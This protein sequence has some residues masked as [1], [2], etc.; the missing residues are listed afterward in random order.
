[1]EPKIN[2]FSRLS[3]TALLS[4][5]KTDSTSIMG[6]EYLD[7]DSKEFSKYK[8]SIAEEAGYS[9][10]QA[11]SIE[12]AFR[13]ATKNIQDLEVSTNPIP[14]NK[15]KFEVSPEELSEVEI[16][17]SREIYN[18]KI[19]KPLEINVFLY[20]LFISFSSMSNL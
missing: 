19:K 17:E 3:N 1:M 18:N 12:E 4:V 11:E 13:T 20:L 7:D 6:D 16:V 15:D 2:I 8:S 5:L 10:T 14:K 9:I